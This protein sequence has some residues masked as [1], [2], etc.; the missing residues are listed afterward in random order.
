MHVNLVP[1]AFLRQ[2][3]GGREK[4]L[5]SAYHVIKQPEKFGVTIEHFFRSEEF[6]GEFN[7]PVMVLT[8]TAPPHLLKR[9]KN[10][11]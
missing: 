4:T 5:A 10:I 1:R 7:I 6:R 3:E 11:Y 8:A 2:G 9:L